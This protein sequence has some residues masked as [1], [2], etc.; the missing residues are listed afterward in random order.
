MRNR[1]DRETFCNLVDAGWLSCQMHPYADLYIYNYTQK[2]Q[3]NTYWLPEILMSRGLIV[4][5]QGY[6]KA[7]PFRKFFNYGEMM[8][9][10]DTQ[11]VEATE[12]CDGSLGVTFWIDDLPYIATRGS[13]VSDQAI[14]ATQWLRDHN[15]TFDGLDRNLT[16]LFEIIYPENR[17]VIDYDGL[18]ALILI[19]GIEIDS[20]RDLLYC[21]LE[22]L[23]TRYG[24]LQPKV[25]RME[26]IEDYLEAAVA[27][28]ANQEGWVVRYSDGERYKIKGDAYR[29]AHKMMTGISFKRVLEAVA[30][31]I[32]DGWIE[33][34]PDEFLVTIREYETFIKQ[35]VIEITERETGL[36]AVAPKSNR[37]EFAMWV[38]ANYPDDQVYLF[39]LLDGRD[40]RPLIYKHAFD[41]VKI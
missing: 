22:V 12:K 30:T 18:S 25:Y 3:Y 20:G 11:I 2:A 15:Q 24:L 8:P 31:D 6:I 1:I 17:V 23:A 38:R 39:A 13:F 9:R 29:L 27:L 32:L 7:R 14:W 21:E 34:V 16:L 28:T 4:D 19:G 37:K 5:G 35:K 33:G 36:F 26:R 41:D 10:Q 40:I